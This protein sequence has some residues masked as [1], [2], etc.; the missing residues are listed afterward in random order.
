MYSSVSAI[1]PIKLLT[2][3]SLKLTLVVTNVTVQ[4]NMCSIGGHFVSVNVLNVWLLES[5]F[6]ASSS[7]Y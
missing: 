6:M 3:R 4:L 7:R 5:S 1:E 2:I